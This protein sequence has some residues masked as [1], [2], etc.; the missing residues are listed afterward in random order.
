MLNC[1]L[2]QPR[3]KYHLLKFYF[4]NNNISYGKMKYL[5][6][7]V[8]LFFRA[9]T[10]IVSTH[11]FLP[12]Q[13]NHSHD[14]PCPVRRHPRQIPAP[15]Q[16]GA[17]LPASYRPTHRLDC[18]IR[19]YEG[20][21]CFFRHLEFLKAACTFLPTYLPVNTNRRQKASQSVRCTTCVPSANGYTSEAQVVR[22]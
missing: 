15:L 19:R 14:P 5:R 1:V 16:A 18:P 12:T 13:L 21:G 22:Q 6:L 11:P 2:S 7:S 10:Y 8:E 17:P 3:K 20:T 9:T 4:K